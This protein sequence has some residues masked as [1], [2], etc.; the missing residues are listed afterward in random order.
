MRVG[1][2][3][4]CELGSSSVPLNRCR[5]SLCPRLWE[6][7]G[8]P[9]L[10][11]CSSRREKL[12]CPAGRSQSRMEQ[13]QPRHHPRPPRCGCGQVLTPQAFLVPRLTQALWPWLLLR[14]VEG[15]PLLVGGWVGLKTSGH[16]SPLLS[17]EAEVTDRT[18][19]WPHHIC[20]SNWC[21]SGGM[22]LAP[23]HPVLRGEWTGSVEDV[24]TPF[25]LLEQ[26]LEARVGVVCT[27]G[28]L[29]WQVAAASCFY[30]FIV[31]S[32]IYV[33]LMNL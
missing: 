4:T 25:P 28:L 10:R 33:M 32:F 30:Y 3:Q 23:T 15:M 29:A 8:V 12:H 6:G 20:H 21:V 9:S 13:S 24:G 26:R 16:F 5:P 2:V 19:A 1:G 14:L 11:P 31:Y 22:S 18:P 7:P 17:A 27:M